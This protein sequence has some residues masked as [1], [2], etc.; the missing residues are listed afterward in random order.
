MPS[1]S[2]ALPTFQHTPSHQ[3]GSR[4][5]GKA[6]IS[7]DCSTL[8]RNYPPPNPLDLH[9]QFQLL[10]TS[11]KS[12]PT[13][14]TVQFVSPTGS[15]DREGRFLLWLELAKIGIFVQQLFQSTPYESFS[16]ST[17]HP[18]S[19]GQA[20]IKSPKGTIL[21]MQ[22]GRLYSPNATGDLASLLRVAFPPFCPN[23]KGQEFGVD[24]PLPQ[25]P[26]NAASLSFSMQ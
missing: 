26:S 7:D 1:P 18:G 20:V 11:P 19:M 2:G 3:R 13:A 23:R 10:K 6:A 17:A 12:P 16:N 15:T 21:W 5:S 8:K 14:S 4:G 25:R 9:Q 22:T 24:A